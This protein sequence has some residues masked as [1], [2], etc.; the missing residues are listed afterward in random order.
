MT[1]QATDRAMAGAATPEWAGR[2]FCRRA[3]LDYDSVLAM[4]GDQGVLLRSAVR[5]GGAIIHV[6]EDQPHPLVVE[7]REIVIATLSSDNHK[8]CHCRAE[9]NAGKWDRGQKVRSA[10][11]GLRRGMEASKSRGQQ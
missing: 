4:D 9:I 8:G 1:D 7:A 5:A 3:N 2:E 10:F 11:E 6:H